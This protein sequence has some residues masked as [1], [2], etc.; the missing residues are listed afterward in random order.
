M[1]FV[2]SLDKHLTVTPDYLGPNLYQ[3]IVDVLMRTVEGSC[4]KRFG[5][6]IKVLNMG[7]IGEGKVKDGGDVLFQVSYRALVFMPY[8]KEVLDATISEVTALGFFANVGP[9][10]LF[11]SSQSFSSDYV[12]HPDAK[13]RPYFVCSQDISQRL[14]IGRNVRLRLN[15]TQVEANDMYGVCTIADDYL[16]PLPA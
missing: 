8:Q 16:G 10:K 4:S 5:Y 1:F 12:L 9:L 13:P 2:L 14:E 15:N 11:V 6:I 3:H 7:D